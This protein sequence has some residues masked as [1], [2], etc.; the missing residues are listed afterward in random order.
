MNNL[1]RSKE[2]S[3][4]EDKYKVV[5]LGDVGVGK[6]SIVERLKHNRFD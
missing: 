2:S 6:S 3:C 1:S 5:L 4:M